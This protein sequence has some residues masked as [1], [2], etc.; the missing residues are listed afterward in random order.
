M[1]VQSFI[2]LSAAV[3]KMSCS[4]KKKW[5]RKQRCHCFCRE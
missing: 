5:C 2:K 4:Q 3:H 1:F